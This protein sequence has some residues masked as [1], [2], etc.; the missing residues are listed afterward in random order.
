MTKADR[1]IINAT[2]MNIFVDYLNTDK[3]NVELDFS[4]RVKMQKTKEK[5]GFCCR[6]SNGSKKP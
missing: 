1:N 6:T 4:R 5:V 2:G 3:S